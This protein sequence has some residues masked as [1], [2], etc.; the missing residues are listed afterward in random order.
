MSDANAHSWDRFLHGRVRVLQPRAGYRAGLDAVLLAAS[1]EAEDGARVAE[2][3]CGAGAAMLCLAARREGVSATGF[4]RD[5]AALALAKAGVEANGLGGRL[6]ARLHDI[7]ERSADLAGAFSQAFA[8]PPYFAPGTTRPPGAGKEA[9][10]I[11]DAPLRD[12]VLFLAHIT[13]RGGRMTLIH[14]AAALAE[15]LAA[16][17]PQAG[18]IEVLPVRPSPGAPAHRVLVRGRKGLR[19]GPLTLYEGLTLHEAEGGALTLRAQAVLG[20]GALDW[21]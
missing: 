10:Y 20:G 2:A 16:I 17:G 7:R 1:I 6:D 4:E 12:W 5:P 18:E 9:A 15:I 8:N 3:G 13:P 21:R 11:A 19:R 14:R